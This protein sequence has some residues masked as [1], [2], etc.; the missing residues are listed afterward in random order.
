MLSCDSESSSFN[1]IFEI[2]ASPAIFLG[3]VHQSDIGLCEAHAF[4]NL[5]GVEGTE[6]TAFLLAKYHKF[7]EAL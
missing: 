2:L 7:R 5:I 4:M 3:I 6:L 1:T